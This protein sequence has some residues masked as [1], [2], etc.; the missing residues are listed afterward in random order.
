MYVI[1]IACNST[2]ADWQ[3]CLCV[4]TIP[5]VLHKCIQ[6]NVSFKTFLFHHFEL[7]R[8]LTESLNQGFSISQNLICFVVSVILHVCAMKLLFL[9]IF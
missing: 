1:M 4:N 5:G 9:L 8:A 2:A 3:N 7:Q 6:S